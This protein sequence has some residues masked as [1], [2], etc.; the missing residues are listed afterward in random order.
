MTDFGWTIAWGSGIPETV[1]LGAVALLGYMFGQRSRP[2][3]LVSASS[4]GPKELQR[5]ARIARQLEETIDAV[6]QSIAKHQAHVSQFKK[7]VGEASEVTNQDLWPLLSSEAENLLV[8]TLRLAT[9][10]SHAYDQLRKHS[11]K[12][13]NFTEGRTDPLT[14][15]GNSLALEEQ[16]ELQL[17]DRTGGGYTA[18]IILVSA[19]P[20]S[21]PMGADDGNRDTTRNIASHIEHCVRDNDY[22]ARIGGNDFAIVLA[23]TPLS[24]ARVFGTRLRSRLELQ[25]GLLANCGIAEALPADTPHA[26]L[27]RADSALYSARADR[28]GAQYLHTGGSIQADRPLAVTAIAAGVDRGSQL[29]QEPVGANC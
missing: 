20:E 19:H 29:V 22:V 3:P 21:A 14:G 1:A 16:L 13:A 23:N 2:Q 24:G 12:L 25:M 5:A 27:S 4:V 7:R 18:S 9:Q 8:P 10:L 28:P 26:L 15:L 11:K 17:A 6:R